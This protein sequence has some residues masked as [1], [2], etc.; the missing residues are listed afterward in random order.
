MLWKHETDWH[1][2]W[3]PSK[4]LQEMVKDGKDVARTDAETETAPFDRA[5]KI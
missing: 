3:S 5:S 2:S 1:L 4:M